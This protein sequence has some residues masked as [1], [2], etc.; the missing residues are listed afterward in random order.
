MGVRELDA[1]QRALAA[2]YAA[3]AGG[4][5][6]WRAPLLGR[7]IEQ[8]GT[9]ALP[10]VFRSLQ[11][12]PALDVFLAEWLDVSAEKD[13]VAYIVALVQIETEARH[14][15]QRETFLLLQDRAAWWQDQQEAAFDRQQQQARRWQPETA[16]ERV[17]P[18]GEGAWVVVVWRASASQ[19]AGGESRHI[20]YYRR[21][22]GGW[23]HAL[24]PFGLA[25]TIGSDY[26]SLVHELSQV[27]DV[28]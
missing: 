22:D 4:A 6:A 25:P 26:W 10:R 8:H 28:P 1:L 13:L 18:S 27:R 24:R 9:E 7:A 11:A 15:G 16:V 17:V 14:A 19:Q 2:E 23:V 3:W 12:G 21:Q 20:D 5:L